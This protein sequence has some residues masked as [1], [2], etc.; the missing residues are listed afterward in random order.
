[1]LEFPAGFCNE[2]VFAAQRSRRLRHAMVSKLAAYA[3][4]FP[5]GTVP[6]LDEDVP[7]DFYLYCYDKL[8]QIID[9]FEDRGIPFEHYCNSVLRWHLRSYFRDRKHLDQRWRVAL[10]NLAWDSRES[11][12]A[13]QRSF[14]PASA[15]P[16]AQP[17]RPPVAAGPESPARV[18]ALRLADPP[19]TF[20]AV[21]TPATPATARRQLA[22]PPRR[23]RVRTRRFRLPKDPFQRRMLYV[24]LKTADL[25]DDREF[26]ALVDATGC[27]PDSLHRL[28]SRL[29]R[30][31]EPAYRRRQMLRD[32]RN[33]AFAALHLCV[34]RARKEPEPGPRGRL[35]RCAARYRRTVAVAQFELS[36]VRI[37]PSNR[38]IATVLGIPK[39]TVDTGLHRLQHNNEPQ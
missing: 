10:Y 4:Q 11:I 30:L 33:R 13:W 38:H 23:R 15:A 17:P 34:V 21:A 24:L 5:H 9:R 8:E 32:R 28:F 1:M 27:H 22:T 14:D 25:L 36:R 20:G 18:P 12:A 2:R 7:G 6:C 26:A 39:G 35:L 16:H 19:G 3:Y 29:E 31:R 37:A